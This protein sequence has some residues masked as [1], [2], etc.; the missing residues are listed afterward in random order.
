MTAPM[1][2]PGMMPMDQPSSPSEGV[3]AKMG[4]L[5]A[6]LREMAGSAKTEATSKTEA[7]AGLGTEGGDVA[8]GETGGKGGDGELVAQTATLTS[9]ALPHICGH[10]VDILIL[11]SQPLQGRQVHFPSL[12]ETVC[13]SAWAD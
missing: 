9:P 10:I 8:E 3:P 4:H 11:A 5:R 6:C 2:A 12:P 13:A 7:A 1:R